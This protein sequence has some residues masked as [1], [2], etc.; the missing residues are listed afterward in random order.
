MTDK[1]KEIINIF[2]TLISKFGYSEI[3]K[4]LETAKEEIEDE[5]D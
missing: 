5:Y 4:L 3:S 1:Q 2:K